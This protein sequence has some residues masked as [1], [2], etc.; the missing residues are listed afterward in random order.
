MLKV[1][2][3]EPK[4]RLPSVLRMLRRPPS[5]GGK[6]LVWPMRRL[7]LL[8]HFKTLNRMSYDTTTTHNHN[9][10]TTATFLAM[11][12]RWQNLQHRCKI[13]TIAKCSRHR[14]FHRRWKL[15]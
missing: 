5:M 6:M 11:R 8:L 3:K 10:P 13:E 7:N 12:N 14:A 2:M 9:N 15:T 4:G 1:Q